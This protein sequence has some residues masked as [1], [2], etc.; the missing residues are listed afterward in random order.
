MYWCKCVY[1]QHIRKIKILTLFQRPPLK[2]AS[3][4]FLHEKCDIQWDNLQ[5]TRNFSAHVIGSIRT[6]TIETWSLSINLLTIIKCV[7]GN[8]NGYPFNGE[9]QIV[10]TLMELN[11]HFD[12][13]V[14][15]ASDVHTT[16]G[17]TARGGVITGDSRGQWW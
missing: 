13:E 11:G 9:I 14:V 8:G 7:Q 15:E 2:K 4:L 16:G 5:N 6:L 12:W 3:A 17:S 1:E 10:G